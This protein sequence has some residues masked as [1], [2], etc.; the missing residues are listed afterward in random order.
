VG[1]RNALRRG[2][3]IAAEEQCTDGQ[4]GG[5]G[6]VSCRRTKPGADG[7][8]HCT[9]QCARQQRK[10]DRKK[11]RSDA[12]GTDQKREP[13]FASPQS[14]ERG[15]EARPTGTLLRRAYKCT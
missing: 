9:H 7:M 8:R 15:Q 2:E 13:G 11:P 12:E 5:Q 1:R 10:D 3:E 6:A 4:E 14:P